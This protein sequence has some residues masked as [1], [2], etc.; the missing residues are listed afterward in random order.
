MIDKSK[1]IFSI[2]FNAFLALYP[3]LV[4]YFLI[5]QK[6]P[7]WVFSLFTIAL[8]LFGFISGIFNKIDKKLGSSFWNSLL[9]FVIGAVSLIINTNIIPKLFPVFINIILLNTFG[10]TLF[11]PPAMIYRFAVLADKSIPESPKQ[12]KIAAY[13]YK[14]TVVWVIFFILNGSTAALTVFYSSDLIWAIYNNVVAP[15][16]IGILFA[17]EFIVRKIVQK[18]Y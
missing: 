5:I 16:L 13:C 1:N 14:V 10:I 18:K 3:I 7:I 11:K 8:A 12:K 17:V 2:V 15:V 4:F 6:I 9:L